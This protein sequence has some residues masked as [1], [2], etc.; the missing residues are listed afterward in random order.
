M[1]NL[2]A[3][4]LGMIVSHIVDFRLTLCKFDT[5]L[6]LYVSLSLFRLASYLLLSHASESCKY[7]LIITVLFLIHIPSDLCLDFTIQQ[8]MAHVEFV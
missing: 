8:S 6:I 4:I 2:K 7:I 1:V 5:Q 3:M